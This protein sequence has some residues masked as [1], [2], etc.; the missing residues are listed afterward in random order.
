MSRTIWK[1]AHRLARLGTRP[2]NFLERQKLD[3]YITMAHLGRR[4]DRADVEMIAD[5]HHA[6][7]C[8]GIQRRLG[9]KGRARDC[10][11]AVKSF[12]KDL[13]RGVTQ[14]VL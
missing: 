6:L 5:L 12:R 3:N 10:I 4:D 7:S 8:A 13:N 11:E 9:F 14:W 1:E 2:R